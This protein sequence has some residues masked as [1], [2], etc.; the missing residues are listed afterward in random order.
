MKSRNIRLGIVG[1]LTAALAL[2]WVSPLMASSG[3]LLYPPGQGL[4]S[5]QPSASE[6]ENPASAAHDSAAHAMCDA[7]P[8]S[9]GAAAGRAVN[10]SA[11]SPVQEQCLNMTCCLLL[12]QASAPPTA[13]PEFIAPYLGLILPAAEERLTSLTFQDLF[14]PPRF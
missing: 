8:P 10:D 6:Q 5:L 12:I 1:L 4:C 13:D 3:Y 7:C 11:P 9:A 14:R 2:G